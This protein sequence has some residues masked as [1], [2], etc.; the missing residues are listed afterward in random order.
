M[1]SILEEEAAAIRQFSPSEHESSVT[2][3]DT[4]L[5]D[6]V[7]S[8]AHADHEDDPEPKESG[9]EAIERRVEKIMTDLREQGAVDEKVMEAKKVCRCASNRRYLIVPDIPFL[10][11]F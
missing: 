3:G 1:A 4:K 5:V 9:S 8:D 7:M 6:A 11:I 10:G 2:N